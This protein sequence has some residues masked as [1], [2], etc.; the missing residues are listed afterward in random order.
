MAAC[1]RFAFWCALLFALPAS[2]MVRD[3]PVAAILARY[4]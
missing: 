1:H 3:G 4:K 2:R